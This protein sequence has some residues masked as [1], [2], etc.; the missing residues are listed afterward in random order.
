LSTFS[1]MLADNQGDVWHWPSTPYRFE[2]WSLDG[3]NLLD[4]QLTRASDWRDADSRPLTAQGIRTLSSDTTAKGDSLRVRVAAMSGTRVELLRV[5]NHERL[6]TF[7]FG[8][9]G[10]RIEVIDLASRRVLATWPSNV[11]PRFINGSDIGYF[12]D[13]RDRNGPITFILLRFNVVGAG[14]H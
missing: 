7:V 2:K 9:D 5:D 10:G 4:A 3:R 11:Q 13:M 1:M 12:R 14:E 8:A 6:W